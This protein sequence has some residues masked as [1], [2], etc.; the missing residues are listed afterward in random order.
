MIVKGTDGV[1]FSY[2][3]V[4][5]MFC[6]EYMEEGEIKVWILLWGLRSCKENIWTDLMEWNRHECYFV[7]HFKIMFTFSFLY[8]WYGQC[9][10]Y[11]ILFSLIA[12][13]MF[14]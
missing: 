10:K 1:G 13:I 14:L 6:K 3:N 8:D 5:W 2:V 4:I 7:G 11:D 9:V 12:H